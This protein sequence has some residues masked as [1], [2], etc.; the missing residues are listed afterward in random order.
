M[1]PHGSAAGRPELARVAGWASGSVGGAWTGRSGRAGS[2]GDDTT[3]GN[4]TPLCLDVNSLIFVGV[5]RPVFKSSIIN[6]QIIDDPSSNLV[7]ASRP[8]RPARL[9]HQVCLDEDI[10]VAVEH[11]IHVADL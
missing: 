11:S 9:L 4:Y 2:N 3:W 7:C 8:Q 6:P 1:A 10:E 5:G